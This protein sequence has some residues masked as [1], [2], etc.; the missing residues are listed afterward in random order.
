[1]LK[2]DE[3]VADL[4]ERVEPGKLARG[5]LFFDLF[6]AEVVGEHLAVVEPVFYFVASGNDSQGIKFADRLEHFIGGREKIIECSGSV[7]R[8]AGIEGIVE[9]LDLRRVMPDGSW[10]FAD[11]EEDPA[12]PLGTDAPLEFQFE[13]GVALAGNDIDPVSAGDGGEETFFYFPAACRKLLLSEPAPLIDGLPVEKNL[14]F[15]FSGGGRS[16]TGD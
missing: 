14:P 12:V 3:A 8:F 1:M 6:G 11:A 16:E 9:D 5:D 7:E 2:A 4:G 13:I 10:L 15:L